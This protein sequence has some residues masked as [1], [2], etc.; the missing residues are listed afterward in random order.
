MSEI[1]ITNTDG[2]EASKLALVIHQHIQTVEAGL[3]SLKSEGAE[4]FRIDA[5]ENYLLRLEYDLENEL[6]KWAYANMGA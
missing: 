1:K 6:T 3:K 2:S 5:L 4:T